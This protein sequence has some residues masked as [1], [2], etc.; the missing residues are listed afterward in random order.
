MLENANASPRIGAFEVS[1]DTGEERATLWSKLLTGEPSCVEASHAVAEH[2][3][4]ELQRRL[5]RT[6]GRT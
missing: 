5:D 4:M 2:V 6:G 1:L 3:V